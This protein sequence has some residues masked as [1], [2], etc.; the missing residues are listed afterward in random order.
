MEPFI[1]K[2]LPNIL[3]KINPYQ[4]KKQKKTTSKMKQNRSNRFAG[5]RTKIDFIKYYK[6]GLCDRTPKE[7]NLIVKLKFNPILHEH[8]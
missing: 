7:I 1:S 2:K 8:M 4:S 5:F 6:N 3:K